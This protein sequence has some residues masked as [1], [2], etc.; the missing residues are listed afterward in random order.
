M[1][2]HAEYELI[3]ILRPDL[4]EDGI[5]KINEKVQA[6]VVKNQAALLESKD[7]GKK[8]LAYRIKKQTRGH[9]IQL[10]FKGPGMVVE[11]VERNLRLTEQVLR[12]LTIRKPKVSTKYPPRKPKME[13]VSHEA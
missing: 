4:A 10:Q 5:K 1:N 2:E 6:I 12:F 13:G 11:E 9:Y 8:P 7:L 3:Y